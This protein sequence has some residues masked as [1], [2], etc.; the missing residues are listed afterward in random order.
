VGASLVTG[1]AL[2]Q[3]AEPKNDEP[4]EAVKN[5][6]KAYQAIFEIARKPVPEHDLL[7]KLSGTWEGES[8]IWTTFTA[9]DAPLTAKWTRTATVEMDGLFLTDRVAGEFIGVP[10]E[11]AGALGYD[12]DAKEYV[13][14]VRNNLGSAVLIMRGQFDAETKTLT[15][16]SDE[17]NRMGMKFTMKEV[18]IFVDDDHITSQMFAIFP[19]GMEAKEFEIDWK[20]TK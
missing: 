13:T 15:L 16:V 9:M 18:F 19:G 17:Q 6:M 14:S 3:D 4:S 8:K 20:R 12:K 5:G 1:A 10:F 2:S 7:Q 11:G